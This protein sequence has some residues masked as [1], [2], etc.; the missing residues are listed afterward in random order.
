MLTRGSGVMEKKF[1]IDVQTHI[2]VTCGVEYTCSST[3]T[4]NNNNK[5]SQGGTGLQEK[6]TCP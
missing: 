5:S 6:R 3:T 1:V 4:N 2:V